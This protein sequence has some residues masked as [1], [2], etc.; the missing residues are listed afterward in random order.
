MQEPFS[1]SFYG[2]DPLNREQS[3]ALQNLTALAKEHEPVCMQAPVIWDGESHSDI[4]YAK[5]GCLGLDTS[6]NKVRPQ[7]PILNEC[8]K[9]AIIIK[10]KHG[11]W[12]GKVSYERRKIKKN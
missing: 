11:V 3:L 5:Q 9:T 6:N 2:I 1:H 8:L 7:C 10:V 12:G 4:A